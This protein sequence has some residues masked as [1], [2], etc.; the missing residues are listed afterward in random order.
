MDE[1]RIIVVRT[2]IEDFLIQFY[3]QYPEVV[4]GIIGGLVIF[5]LF[6]LIGTW[7]KENRKWR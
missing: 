1:P 5:I 4:L 3:D 6:F 2:P 7:I